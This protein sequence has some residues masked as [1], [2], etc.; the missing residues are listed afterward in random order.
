MSSVAS[1]S[2]KIVGL[3]KKPIFPDTSQKG[4]GINKNPTD[5]KTGLIVR[6]EFSRTWYDRQ[7]TIPA[8]SMNAILVKLTP[9]LLSKQDLSHSAISSE[10]YYAAIIHKI[11][12]SPRVG[13]TKVIKVH[14]RKNG[15]M[16]KTNLKYSDKRLHTHIRISAFQQNES[17]LDTNCKLGVL[18]LFEFFVDTIFPLTLCNEFLWQSK[19]V[20]WISHGDWLE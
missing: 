12:H 15:H 20:S 6:R 2:K 17:L 19:S 13:R 7:A 9:L 14:S 3:S 11:V 18:L 1:R 10:I 8:N 4:D 16:F 5:S